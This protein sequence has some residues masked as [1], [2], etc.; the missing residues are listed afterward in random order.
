MRLY[1]L[2]TV[3]WI[4]AAAA[5]IG[6]GCLHTFPDDPHLKRELV[7][8]AAMSIKFVAIRP[9][10]FAK[11]STTNKT[12]EVKQYGVYLDPQILAS[13]AFLALNGSALAVFCLIKSRVRKLKN[14]KG[15]NAEFVP[16]NT[17]DIKFPYKEAFE[18]FLFTQTRFTRAIDDLVQTGFLDIVKAGVP[19]ANIPTIYGLSLRWMKYK[20][21]EFEEKPRPRAKRGF[22]KSRRKQKQPCKHGDL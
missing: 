11:N 19:M 12:K 14:G 16:Q 10:Q 22:C 20:T 17:L 6:G 21:C 2:K 1:S 3:S 9:R 8:A 4:V 13:K 7:G 18:F 15:K 5:A